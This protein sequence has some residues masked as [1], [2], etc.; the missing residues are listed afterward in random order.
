MLLQQK[1]K[2][3]ELWMAGGENKALFSTHFAVFAKFFLEFNNLIANMRI[4]K[5]FHNLKSAERA[6][7][8]KHL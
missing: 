5:R 7:S 4:G 8:Q 1:H 3:T 2:N 6:G